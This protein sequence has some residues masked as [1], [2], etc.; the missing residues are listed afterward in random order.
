MLS[1]D[2]IWRSNISP[3]AKSYL[4]R[5]FFMY[6]M[7]LQTPVMHLL[8]RWS[9]GL[10]FNLCIPFIGRAHSDSPSIFRRHHHLTIKLTFNA[11]IEPTPS[12]PTAFGDIILSHATECISFYHH[13]RPTKNCVWFVLECLW[14]PS[15]LWKVR[16]SKL[17]GC[18]RLEWSLSN[19]L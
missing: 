13:P 3:M 19:D 6:A 8:D 17:E 15:E 18:P 14:P 1:S 5:F 4:L 10:L 16:S 12:P 11:C 2:L 7:L 9:C